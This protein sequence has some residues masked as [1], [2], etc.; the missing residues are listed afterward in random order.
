MRI[1]GQAAEG[2]AFAMIVAVL[3]V[4]IVM[5][6]MFVMIMVMRMPMI[7][8]VTRIGAA[9]RRER[10]DDVGYRRAKTF[11]HRLDDMIAQD[12]DAAGLDR[13]G[14]MPVAN[15]PGEFGEMHAVP[16]AYVVKLFGR[17]TDLDLP[18]V[19][20]HQPV[21]IGERHRLG[22]VDQHLAA[23]GKLNGA[24]AQMPLVMHKHGLAGDGTGCTTS[25]ND[26]NRARK[27]GEIGVERKLHAG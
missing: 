1:A 21:A 5:M 22:K 15:M 3:M 13:G 12:E 24:A 25:Q 20:Q 26:G 19:L 16:G 23:V 11:K 14:E 4:V 7:M 8:A 6:I 10:L 18:S 9:H 27:F 17:R 2:I